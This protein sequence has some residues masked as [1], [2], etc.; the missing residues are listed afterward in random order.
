MSNSIETLVTRARTEREALGLLY[1][2]HFPAMY[3]YCLH[4][5]FVKDV[6][7]DITSRV[8][9]KV[10]QA[11]ERFRGSTEGEFRTW[12]YRIATNEINL[13]L[14][15]KKQREALLKT[16]ITRTELYGGFLD[17]SGDRLRPRIHIAIQRLKLRDQAIVVMR[18]FDDLNIGQ[19]CEILG[20]KR[21]TIRVALVRALRRLRE[22]LRDTSWDDWS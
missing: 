20:Y 1:D 16:V 12:L 19:I 18:Y 7:E 9:L 21:G 15:R 4:R 5:L 13:Y 11:I 10:V 6:A 17:V 3:R 8:F 2:R 22:D 14:R